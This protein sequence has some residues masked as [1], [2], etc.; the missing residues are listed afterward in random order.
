MPVCVC[1]VLAEG[2][3]AMVGRL[4]VHVLSADCRRPYGQLHM[5]QGGAQRET[6][7]AH[8]CSCRLC[9]NWLNMLDGVCVAYTL[10]YFFFF[11]LLVAAFERNQWFAVG[12]SATQSVLCVGGF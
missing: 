10:F 2:C 6:L 11:S 9:E 8:S 3:D 4:R 12:Q 7:F 1:N 5:H